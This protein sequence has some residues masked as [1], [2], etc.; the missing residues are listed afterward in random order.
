[1][2]ELPLKIWPILTP[3][4]SSPARLTAWKTTYLDKWNKRTQGRAPGN[5]AA[6]LA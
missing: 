3:Y 5:V 2:R 1:M 4:P 6:S